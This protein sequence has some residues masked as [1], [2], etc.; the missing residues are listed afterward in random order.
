MRGDNMDWLKASEFKNRLKKDQKF[1]DELLLSQDSRDIM[2]KF[3]WLHLIDNDEIPLYKGQVCMCYLEGHRIDYPY[4]VEL[5]D[6]INGNGWKVTRNT[7]SL[8]I[9][10]M[11]IE[12]L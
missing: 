5:L 6:F 7:E 3:V 4:I 2:K 8:F 12:K 10:T 11:R 1:F 9:G